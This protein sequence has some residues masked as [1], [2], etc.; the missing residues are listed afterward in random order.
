V[1]HDN[2]SFVRKI[3]QTKPI[4]RLHS[5]SIPIDHYCFTDHFDTLMSNEL[6]Q[7]GPHTIFMTS[8]SQKVIKNKYNI[9]G[10]YP[11]H[12]GTDTSRYSDATN[13]NLL[14]KRLGD[15]DSIH[16]GRGRYYTFPP[17]YFLV[18]DHFPNN[19]KINGEQFSGI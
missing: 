5:S 13:S 10:I 1:Y 17:D 16:Y 2:P 11:G 15:G 12:L 18:N 19:I 9:M 6:K 14:I 8:L 4:Q 3:V 7:S